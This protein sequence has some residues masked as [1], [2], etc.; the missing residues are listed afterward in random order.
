MI[1]IKLHICI[2]S[3]CQT[4]VR[5]NDKVCYL[6]YVAEEDIPETK[7]ERLFRVEER[8]DLGWSVEDHHSVQESLYHN[9]QQETSKV[10]YSTI[11]LRL[12]GI[13]PHSFYVRS[14][15]CVYGFQI[16]TQYIFNQQYMPFNLIE[17]QI[18]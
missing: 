7:C 8:V 16:Q 12:M 15:F 14:R 1:K 10:V 17:K 2:Q 6:L 5:T 18:L 13:E 9:L 4:E 3:Y 11:A